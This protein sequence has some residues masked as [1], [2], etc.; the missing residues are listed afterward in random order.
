MYL[1]EVS[2]KAIMCRA[3]IL[4]SDCLH[5]SEVISMHVSVEHM[6]F[7][8]LYQLLVGC[9]QVMAW[10]FDEGALVEL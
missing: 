4:L 10:A 8:I 1:D 6:M 5:C 7:D 2:K 3:T 9:L